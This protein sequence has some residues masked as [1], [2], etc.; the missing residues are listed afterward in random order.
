MSNRKYGLIFDMDGVIADTEVLNAIAGAKALDEL[1]GLKGVKR[2]DFEAGVGRGDYAYMRAGGEANGLRMSESDVEK[3]FAA[4]QANVIRMLE[5]DPLPA[6]PGVLMLMNGAIESGEWALA[7]AT[8]SPKEKTESVLSSAKVPREKFVLVTGS[9]PFP[10]K[11]APDMFLAAAE[12]IGV[13]PRKCVVVEDSVSGVKAAKAAGMKCIAVTNSFPADRLYEADLIVA[14][15][16]EVSLARL[17]EL[18]A[19]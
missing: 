11:P 9:E 4:M 6:F 13:P 12:R 18:L 8:G 14:S 15:L 16:A 19:G 1:F 2:K 7:V 5:E 17:V 3:A 10:K